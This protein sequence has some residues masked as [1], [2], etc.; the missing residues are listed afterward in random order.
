MNL[1]IVYYTLFSAIQIR[2]K[3]LRILGYVVNN[4]LE[5]MEKDLPVAK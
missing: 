5:R 3:W 1:S 2:G 4:E